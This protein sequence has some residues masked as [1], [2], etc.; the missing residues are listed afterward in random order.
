MKAY[1]DKIAERFDVSILSYLISEI[2]PAEM[3]L[4]KIR[5]EDYFVDWKE[6]E[7]VLDGSSGESIQI[8]SQHIQTFVTS[9]LTNLEK[10][11]DVFPEP[12]DEARRD[13]EEIIET[14]KSAI[15]DLGI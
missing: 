12:F 11:S 5:Y 7:V 3:N 1:D 2:H 8:L 10:Q 4:P 9:Y 14:I 15:R 13:N 6:A